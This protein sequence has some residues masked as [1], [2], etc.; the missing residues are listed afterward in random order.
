MTP[1]RIVVVD[2][3]DALRG[4]GEPNTMRPAVVIG[5]P[6]LYGVGFG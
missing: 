6:D 5:R 4:S 1:G 2:W 3:R